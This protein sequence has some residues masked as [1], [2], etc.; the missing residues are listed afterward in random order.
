MSSTEKYRQ[1]SIRRITGLRSLVPQIDSADWNRAF[2]A[3]NKYKCYIKTRLLHLLE[4]FASLE[5]DLWE[6]EW[7][8]PCVGFTESRVRLRASFFSTFIGKLLI[9][10][11]IAVLDIFW[12]I[13]WSEKKHHSNG[14]QLGWEMGDTL[15]VC[16]GHTIIENIETTFVQTQLPCCTH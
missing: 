13:F 11:S 6:S 10:R 9:G 1:E 4:I 12:D 5:S 2:P 8:P 16:K 3:N 14:W 15:N 7:N